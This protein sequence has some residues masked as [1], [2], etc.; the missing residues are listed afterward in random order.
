MINKIELMKVEI[1]RYSKKIKE[2]AKDNIEVTE[3][4]LAL[5]KDQIRDLEREVRMIKEGKGNNQE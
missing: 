5:K 1:E 2:I 3:K 4:E